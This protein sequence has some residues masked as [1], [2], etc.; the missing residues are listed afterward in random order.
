VKEATRFDAM[1]TQKGSME[2]KPLEVVI[3]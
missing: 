1:S 3:E 2:E